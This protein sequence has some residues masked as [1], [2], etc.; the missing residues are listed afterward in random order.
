MTA[1]HKGTAQV[2]SRDRPDISAHP[3]PMAFSRAH[4]ATQDKKTRT[5]WLLEPKQRQNSRRNITQRTFF[6]VLLSILVV[7]KHECSIGILRPRDNEGNLVGRVR[8]VWRTRVQV[9]H[10]FRVTMVSR[11]KEGV[12]CLL[13]RLI[14]RTNCRVSVCNGFDGSLKNARMADL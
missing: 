10:L 13:A 1:T 7:H 12:P 14:D 4:K 2:T 9:H 3:R 8:R 5:F 11:D 6:R